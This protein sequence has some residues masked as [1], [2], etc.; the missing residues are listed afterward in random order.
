MTRALLVLVVF[1]ACRSNDEP[2]PSIAPIVG[3]DDTCD[4]TTPKV[5]VGPDVVACEKDGHLGRRLR[6]CHDGC[7]S[8]RCKRT[9]DDDET[10]LV[11]VVD[12]A[13]DLLRFDPRKLPGDPFTLV[14]KLGCDDYGSPFSMSVDRGGF[15][16][17]VYDSGS[18]FKVSIDDA[19]CEP[20]KFRPGT[21]GARTFGMG[22]VTDKAGSK[23][24]H[25]ML[26]KNDYSH[27]LVAMDTDDNLSTITLGRIT[28]AELQNPE[29]TGTGEGRLFGF[30]PVDYGTSFVQE[31]D[32]S[33][34]AP[35]GD[36]WTL[37]TAPLGDISAYAFAH[38]AGAFYIFA[39]IDGNNNVYAVDRVSRK[40]SLVREHTPY[41]VT[42]AGVSTCAP[43]RDASHP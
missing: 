29:L 26:A 20:T 43:E 4:P 28:A 39:T 19:T 5:C 37:G 22:F 33:S 31:I 34:G 21:L 12:S 1:A 14:G 27:E 2:K 16:W 10:K 35:L 13:N 24:E 18:L 8:G 41:R 6:A 25:L 11:Y 38:W 42:G 23:D 40:F 30:Y 15:A 3:E 9:C 7:K 36:P 17:V 32:R